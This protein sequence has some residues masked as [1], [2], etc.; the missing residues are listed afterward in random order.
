VNTTLNIYFQRIIAHMVW[1]GYRRLFTLPSF[2][3]NLIR[4]MYR[5]YILIAVIVSRLDGIL[6]NE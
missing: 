2:D 1:F 3:I 4:L 5:L 6:V